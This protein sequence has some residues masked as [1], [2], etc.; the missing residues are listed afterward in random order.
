MSGRDRRKVEASIMR[1]LLHDP[2][3]E[4]IEHYPRRGIDYCL[5]EADTP[6]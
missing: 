1:E 6:H 4:L 2:F 3:Y 5:I